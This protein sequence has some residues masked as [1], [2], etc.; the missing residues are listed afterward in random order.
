MADGITVDYHTSDSNQ[1]LVAKGDHSKQAILAAAVDQNVIDKDDLQ[2]FQA[3]DYYQSNFKVVPTSD[4][5]GYS[6]WQHR[7]EKPCRGS[8]FASVL[9]K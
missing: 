4:D 1:F 8:Y 6:C 3:A 5:S 9:C 2:E 7:V